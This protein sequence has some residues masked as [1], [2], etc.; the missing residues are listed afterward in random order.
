MKK[1]FFFSIF[2]SYIIVQSLNSW[3][4][5]VVW[6]EF[7]ENIDF[8]YYQ[9]IYIKYQFKAVFFL[10]NFQNLFRDVCPSSVSFSTRSSVIVWYQLWVGLSSSDITP[11]VNDDVS[12]VTY[13]K[14]MNILELERAVPFPFLVFQNWNLFSGVFY[15]KI[16]TLDRD[17]W[18]EKC[19]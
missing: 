17:I 15:S 8:A 4:Y 5:T 9:N 13:Y 14:C 2:S 19:K 11:G 16:S 10:S 6:F 18:S 7:L 3:K 12:L 1:N